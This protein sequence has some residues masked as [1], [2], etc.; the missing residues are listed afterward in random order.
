M[1]SASKEGL[2]L[3]EEFREKHA[4]GNEPI[5]DIADFMQLVDA[6]FMILDLP[7]NVD[8]LALR[9]PVTGATVIGI[10]KSSVPYRQRFTVAHEIG[11]FISSDFE[12]S[13]IVEDDGRSEPG[14]YVCGKRDHQEVRADTFARNVLC[15]TDGLKS[16]HK[17]SELTSSG[18]ILAALSHVVRR[19]QISPQVALI[20]MRHAGLISEEQS[21]ELKGISAPAL[22]ARYG[23]KAD[24]DRAVK[25]SG[26]V[27]PSARLVKDTYRA[28]ER[29]IVDLPSIAFAEMSSVDEVKELISASQSQLPPLAHGANV[30]DQDVVDVEPDPFA[31]LDAFFGD[32]SD[33]SNSSDSSES[34]Q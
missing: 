1:C 19:Y 29:G 34:T 33:K 32:A 27:Q 24:Y 30:Q 20:Q 10:A 7:D 6:D 16:D 3:A 22:A 9:D 4:L 12:S 2:N 21:E 23:W 28:Y 11:H 17:L 14:I 5:A 8:A 26:L 31:E 18:D 15:P 25:V 13:K